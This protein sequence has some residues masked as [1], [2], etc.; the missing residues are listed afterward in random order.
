MKCQVYGNGYVEYGGDNDFVFVS[1]LVEFAL[2][3]AQVLWYDNIIV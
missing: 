3:Y 1:N 2:S